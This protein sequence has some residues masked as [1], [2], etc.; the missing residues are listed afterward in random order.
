VVE[1][2][3]SSPT[4][5]EGGPV[6]AALQVG[7]LDAAAIAAIRPRL[8][9]ILMDCVADGASVGFLEQLDAAEADRYWQRVENAVAGG[10]RILLVAASSDGA[11]AGTVQLD[12]NTMPNQPHRGTVSKLLVHTAQR[13]QGI[14]E[15]LMAAIE[16]AA[17][18]SGRWL[19]T[20]DT[21]TPAAERLYERMG[22]TR[23]GV[24]PDYALNPDG[25]PTQTA[26]YWKR[27]PH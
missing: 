10:R 18:D 21:A 16:R 3:T 25:T 9:E 7:S 22:W 11:V 6:I 20:L 14:G 24:I 15:A 19:L 1:D 17:L 27:L 23:A 2:G 13:R 12:V 8:T 4:A 26:Y 5:G